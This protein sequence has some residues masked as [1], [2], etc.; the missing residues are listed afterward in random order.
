MAG[1]ITLAA[2]ARKLGMYDVRLEELPDGAR[3]RQALRQPDV[4]A[5]D[6][7]Q[8]DLSLQD[9]SHDHRLRIVDHQDVV[10]PDVRA[11]LLG[12]LAPHALEELA[13]L[14]AE[15]AAPDAVDHVVD[16]LRELEEGLAIG[17]DDGPVGFDAQ[18]PQHRDHHRQHL[19]DAASL[20]RRVDHPELAAPERRH[21][22][23]GLG[24]QLLD[25]GGEKGQIGVVPEPKRLVDL[26]D[27]GQG[28]PPVLG[29]TRGRGSASLRA[30]PRG[31]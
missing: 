23:A 4:T 15:L 28:V 21:Q 5:P 22:R 17:L 26:D 7:G 13:V 12:V 1:W 9:R 19:G 27:A 6:R 2:P 29:R 8:A 24:P 11:E 31:N 14:G 10:R 18:L 3:G 20:G 30:F 25:R 16:A